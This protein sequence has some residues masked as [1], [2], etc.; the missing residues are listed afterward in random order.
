MKGTT[1][2]AL[3][4]SESGGFSFN[5]Y[6]DDSHNPVFYITGKDQFG[7]N[8][9]KRITFKGRLLP[10]PNGQKDSQGMLLVDFLRESPY[11]LQEGEDRTPIHRF[12]ELDSTKAAQ[13]KNSKDKL[14]FQAK[15]MIYN[16]EDDVLSNISAVFGYLGE[17]K[18]MKLSTCLDACESNP[19]RVISVVDSDDTEYRATLS[20][21]IEHGVVKRNGF[22]IEYKAPKAPKPITIG[23]DDDSAVNKLMKDKRLYDSLLK[24]LE[25][26]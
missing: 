15:G 4:N 5:S 24:Q 19:E 2:F 8:I 20:L 1:K 17:D 11:C 6:N 14:I 18:E 25:S 12:K 21:L 3:L 10:V 16:A 7:N 26:K 22:L 9:N 23:I 13:M